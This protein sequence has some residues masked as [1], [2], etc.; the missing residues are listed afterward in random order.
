MNY[1][2]TEFLH[3]FTQIS[4]MWYLNIITVHYQNQETDIGVMLSTKLQ[5]LLGFH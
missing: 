1:K 5:T 3:A 4:P 2:N